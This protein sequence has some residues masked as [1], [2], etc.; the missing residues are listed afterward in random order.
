MGG[1]IRKRMGKEIKIHQSEQTV[2][3]LIAKRE[4]PE[5][6]LAQ[7]QDTIRNDMQWVYKMLRTGQGP[8]NKTQYNKFMNQLSASLY[9]FQSQGRVGAIED[10]KYPQAS[11]LLADNTV[12][13]TKF[14]TMAKFGYQPVLLPPCKE[15]TVLMKAY[16]GVVR[17]KVLITFL[18]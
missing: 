2:E 15:S 7:L 1:T 9:T 16:I 3:V 13:S 4:W 10:L 18:F 11:E 12:M 17:P 6:G 8:I 5:G 14:K